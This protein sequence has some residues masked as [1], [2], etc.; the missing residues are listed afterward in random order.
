[1]KQGIVRKGEIREEGEGRK[2]EKEKGQGRRG[3]GEETGMGREWQER[4]G[5]EVK[6]ARKKKHWLPS[7][8]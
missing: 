8:S 2:R 6:E 3:K 4:G 7:L 1:M 5:K